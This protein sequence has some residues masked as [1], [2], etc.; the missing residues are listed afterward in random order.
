MLSAIANGLVI[1]GLVILIGTLFPVRKLIQQLPHGPLRQ[2]WFFQAG[3]ILAFIL[4]YL[5]YTIVFWWHSNR[6][7]DLIVPGVFFF[8]AAFVWM[9]ITLSL[10]TALDVRRVALLEQEN[11]T[12]PLI[13]VYNRRFL[14][15]RLIEEYARAKRYQEQL[16]LLLID[17]D[18]FKRVNDTY[19]HQIGDQVLRYWGGLILGVV[20]ATDIVAR[21]GGEEVIVIVP[22]TSPAGAL[23]LAERIRVNI[24]GHELVLSSEPNRRQAIRITVS[25]GV[26]SLTPSTAGVDE[27]LHEADRALYSAKRGGRNRV[28][29]VEEIQEKSRE[30]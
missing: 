19:G 2:K 9:T 18:H 15:R 29:V 17:I 4:G 28:V 20:R 22:N 12:D 14:N 3:L 7:A 26:A 10:Q 1:S 23:S 6:L 13:G 30:S 27:F 16:S 11:I 25:I 21:Y 24:E 8:G 5:A